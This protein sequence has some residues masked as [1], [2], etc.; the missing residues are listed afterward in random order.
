V[1]GAYLAAKAGL[2]FEGECVRL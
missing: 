2:S 1:R